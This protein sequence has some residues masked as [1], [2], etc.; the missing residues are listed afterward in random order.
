M[1]IACWSVK[2]GSGTSVVAASLAL[3]LARSG[4]TTLVDL[5]GDAPAILGLPEPDGPGVAE[6]LAAGD[7]DA[8]GL[9]RVS[10]EAAPGVRLVPLGRSPL[11]EGGGERLAAALAGPSRVVIDC[12]SRITPGPGLGVAAAA[13]VSLLIVRPCYLALR[14]AIAAPLRPSGVVLIDEGERSLGQTD[15]AEV[16]GVPVRA[17]LPWDPR[18][19]R[20]VDAGLLVARMPR[21]LRALEAAA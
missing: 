10:V 19:A 18:V 1:L 8:G 12:G 21:S 11:P 3:Q 14:R 20:A 5:G 16:L 17:V 7:V 13:T 9:S 15:V 6:W 4:D 2:G